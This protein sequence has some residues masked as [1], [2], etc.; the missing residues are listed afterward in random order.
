MLE[1]LRRVIGYINRLRVHLLSSLLAL[2]DIHPNSYYPIC[3]SIN[4]S[5][6]QSILPSSSLPISVYSSPPP[7]LLLSPIYY[8]SPPT[9]KQLPLFSKNAFPI[10]RWRRRHPIFAP[11]NNKRFAHIRP[12]TSPLYPFS[13]GARQ[14]C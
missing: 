12:N 9:N 5:P 4:L 13:Q 1:A 3:L 7:H 14:I 8:Q 6:T 10:C 2:L 11:P